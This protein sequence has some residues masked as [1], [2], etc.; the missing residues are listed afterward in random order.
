LKNLFAAVRETAP[1]P[2]PAPLALGG[3]KSRGADP[4]FGLKGGGG[5]QSC[6]AWPAGFSSFC[7]LGFFFTQN[8]G[9]GPSP[10]SATGLDMREREVE[11]E[12]NSHTNTDISDHFAYASRWR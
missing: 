10:G 8:K 4:D 1:P 7:E 11:I 6:F 3:E 2:P 5:A 9:G 12:P